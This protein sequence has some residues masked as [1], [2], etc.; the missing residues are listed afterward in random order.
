MEKFFINLILFA[1]LILGLRA[2]SHYYKHINQLVILD[3][4]ACQYCYDYWELEQCQCSLEARH[5]IKHVS[6]GE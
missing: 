6:G 3:N 1:L 2:Y 4:G 5:P